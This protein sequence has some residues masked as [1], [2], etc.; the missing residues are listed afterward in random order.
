[1]VEGCKPVNLVTRLLCRIEKNGN[2]TKSNSFFSN[3]L[4]CLRQIPQYSFLIKVFQKY[5]VV[6][7]R[8]YCKNS[9]LMHLFF[10]S[11]LVIDREKGTTGVKFCMDFFTSL[12]RNLFLQVIEFCDKPRATMCNVWRMVKS[13]EKIQ[14][15]K[16]WRL[17]A[18][19]RTI[20][21]KTEQDHIFM[22]RKSLVT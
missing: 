1:M 17:S 21:L 8:N 22:F 14:V 11:D 15:L 12:Q 20:T 9:I 4:Y 16:N 7:S 6:S 5:F 19:V 18:L 2:S 10:S 13:K 3:V